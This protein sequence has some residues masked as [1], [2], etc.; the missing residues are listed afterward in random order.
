MAFFRNDAVNR[1][2]LHFALHALAL[3][4]GGAFYGAFLLRAGAPAPVVLASLAL[5]NLARF[6]LR[7][8]VIFPARRFGLKPLVIAGTL[9]CSL[10]YPLLAGVQGVGWR[11]LGLLMVSSF[12]DTIYWAAYHAY[13][14]S[15]GDAEHRGHQVG[16]REALT[17]LMSTVAPLVTGWALSAFGPVVAFYGTALAVLTAALP[18]LRAPN[19]R[20][21]PRAPGAFRAALRGTLIFTADG[22]SY[23]A[24]I[25]W[26]IALFLTV[27]ES[28]AGYGLALAIAALAGAVGSLRLGR[29]IDLGHGAR[30]IWIAGG[31]LLVTDLL[32]AA[33]YGSLA[34]AV[35]VNAA[36]ALAGVLAAPAMMTAV[37]NLAKASPCAMRYQIAADGGWDAGAGLACLAA[38]ALLWL[39]APIQLA[40]LLSVPGSLAIFVQ[41]RRYYAASDAAVETLAATS[42]PL[43]N[44]AQS[45]SDRG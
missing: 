45:V 4:G 36:G 1:L 21:Q 11:L 42:S 5:V 15:L 12:G 16:A 3:S 10:Q 34:P 8:L 41:L 19:V 22:W 18:L 6:V 9:L 23:G 26:Q 27:R 28:F 33:S 17:A 13:Y 7:P 30:V 32:R 37:Y 2:N 25:V 24:L 40:I 35:A 14:A 43:A 38:A 31:A 29:F 39:G 44:A 20:I